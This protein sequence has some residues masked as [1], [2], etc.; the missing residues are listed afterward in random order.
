MLITILML[1][2]WNGSLLKGLVL[3]TEATLSFKT[4]KINIVFG[5]ALTGEGTKKIIRCL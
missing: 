4:G 1:F 3:R 5:G 2:H